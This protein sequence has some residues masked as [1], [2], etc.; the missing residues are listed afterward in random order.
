MICIPHRC[1]LHKNSKGRFPY[2]GS[3]LSVS[4]SGYAIFRKS[5]FIQIKETRIDSKAPLQGAILATALL[6][7]Q[8]ARQRYPS[9]NLHHAGILGHH[10]LRIVQE[11]FG[12]FFW[13]LEILPFHGKVDLLHAGELA[14]GEQYSAN[15]ACHRR[16]YW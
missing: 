15:P 1:R 12:G 10:L 6:C 5:N 13:G 11:G 8:P 4:K 14:G 16:C 9:I 7:M 3:A 2:G